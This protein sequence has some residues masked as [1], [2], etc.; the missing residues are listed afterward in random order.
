MEPQR[1]RAEACA[2]EE[3]PLRLVSKVHACLCSHGSAP[4]CRPNSIR[5]ASGHASAIRQEP[6]FQFSRQARPGSQ[7]IVVLY[8]VMRGRFVPRF[9]HARLFAG[10]LVA[11]RGSSTRADG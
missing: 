10:L 2:E 9:S 4:A 11:D 5:L 8:V 3:E 1:E 6:M 7:R